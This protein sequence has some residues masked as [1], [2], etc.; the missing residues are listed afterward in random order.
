MTRKIREHQRSRRNPSP[1][2][3]KSHETAQ[4]P[5]GKWTSF[6]WLYFGAVRLFHKVDSLSHWRQ[7]SGLESFCTSVPYLKGTYR[8]DVKGGGIGSAHNVNLTLNVNKSN[9]NDPLWLCLL[10]FRKCK[11]VTMVTAVTTCT[12]YLPILY[13]FSTTR[14]KYFVVITGYVRVNSSREHPPAGQTPGI[15]CTVGA[16]GRVFGS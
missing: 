4:M 11:S 12:L 10:L 5:L 2:P 6:I 7:L 3:T 14:W 13:N 1:N 8:I 15:W 9:S 16:G